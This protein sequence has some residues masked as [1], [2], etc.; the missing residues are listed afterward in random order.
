MLHLTN[1]SVAVDLLRRAGIRGAIV[2]WDDVLHE[3]PVPAG[4][5]PAALRARRA[6]FLASC[7]W[8]AV[9]AI[10]RKLADRDDA[11]ARA[12]EAEEIVLW[13]EHD[14][15]DQLQLLQILNALPDALQ[16]P[17]TIA[18]VD[19]YI[20]HLSVDR[21]TPLFEGRCA[22]TSAQRAAARDAW[23]AFRHSDPRLIVN[24]LP[25]VDALPHVAPALSRHLQQ[26]PGRDDGLSRTERQA[27]AVI[28]QG[29]RR[30]REVFR[31]VQ[32]QEE[33][34]FMG[35]AA[36]LVHVGALARGPR[37]LLY[38]VRHDASPIARDE[39]LDLETEVAL[40]QDGEQ[41]LAGQADRIAVNGIDR[42][43]GGVQLRGSGP[44]WRWHGG[45]MV[46]T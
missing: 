43:L 44:V 36:F 12:A 5:G 9:D 11:M 1:G 27:L 23:A 38:V 42:W 18:P 17:I 37:P 6:A 45:T 2:P 30:M 19:D 24:V 13:F 33:A 35:D 46:L 32:R 31:H 41:V 8:G 14:L 29:T 26:F 16:P 39:P 40:T 21:I 15:Y 7:G 4:L 28:A 10:E 20:G 22:V 34:M 25:R 3:G